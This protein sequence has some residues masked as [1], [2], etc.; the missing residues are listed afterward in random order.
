LFLDTLLDIAFVLDDSKRVISDPDPCNLQ[1]N[2]A[3]LGADI[4]GVL[5][6]GV[7]G[8]GLVV[9]GARVGN[10]VIGK[11]ITGFTKHGINQTISRGLRPKEILGIMRSGQVKQGRDGVL[12]FI[13]KNGEARVNKQ[14]NVVTGIRFKSPEVP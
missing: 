11:T 8:L 3:I 12:R 2:L 10:R 9:R 13:G 1:R 14:G 6:P 4:A 5:L 7:T